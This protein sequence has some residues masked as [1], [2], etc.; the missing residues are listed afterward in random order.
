M[1]DDNRKLWDRLGKTDPIHTKSFKRTGGFSGTAIKPMWAYKRMTE[2][3]GPCGKGWGINKPEFELQH[4]DEDVLVFCTVSV[5]H[6]EPEQLTWGVGGDRI[7]SKN[8]H[9]LYVDDEAYKKAFTDAVTNA[10]KFIGVGADVHM[11]MY[12]DN[13]YVNALKAEFA[14]EKQTTNGGIRQNGTKSSAQLKREN[15][16]QEF[17]RELAEC[18]TL[19]SLD[20]LKTAWRAKAE[21]EKWNMSFLNAMKDEFAKRADWIQQAQPQEQAQAAE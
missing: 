3:F 7:R 6:E 2:E 4:M 17:E 5:W 19:V 14:E 9:G 11:G 1:S 21:A 20:K 18:D 16:W 12:D 8:R 10:L 15:V 13:K